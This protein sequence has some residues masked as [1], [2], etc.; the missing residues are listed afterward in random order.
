MDSVRSWSLE[1]AWA[2]SLHDG[3]IKERYGVELKW[4][5]SGAAVVGAPDMQ[6]VELSVG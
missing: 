2:K 1:G 4:T 3:K 5:A 6:D